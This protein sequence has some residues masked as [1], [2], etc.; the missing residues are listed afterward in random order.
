MDRKTALICSKRFQEHET[1]THPENGYRL[2]AISNRMK[3]SGL[4]GGRAVYEPIEASVQDLLLV[5]DPEYVRFI[6][7]IALVGGGYLD[8]DTVISPRS[9]Q[10]ACLAAGA[11]I[12]AV[13]L[14]L[15]GRHQRVFVLPRPPGHHAGRAHGM[16]FCLFNN[17][18]IAAR[19]AIDRHG[20]FRVAI[21]DWDVHHGNGTQAIF[22]DSDQVFYASMHQW[23]LFPGTGRAQEAGVRYGYG[24]TLNVPLTSGAGDE[25]YVQVIDEIIAP[26]LRE[27]RPEL[28]LVSAGFDAHEGDPLA[29]MRVTTD[30]FAE[31]ARHI[32]ELADQLCHGR[33]VAVLE[34]GYNPDDLA[35]SVE[36]VLK[37][38]DSIP[39]AKEI[40]R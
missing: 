25:E 11:S 38:F 7:Q 16:G 8:A 10:V 12:Q 21:V 35:A 40:A 20:L 5:H 39:Q 34:G 3:R 28:M 29:S 14:V 27:F 13:D 23:P 37:S 32:R 1:G 19:H 17:V 26:R 4:L 30:G 22:Q 31:M 18:A 15:T 36:A 33:L 24:Y 2:E 6:E 9:Y